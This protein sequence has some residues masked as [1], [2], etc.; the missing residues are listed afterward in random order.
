MNFGIKKYNIRLKG[1]KKQ[2]KV[3]K[4]KTQIIF[5]TNT[6]FDC[7]TC[8]ITEIIVIKIL[9]TVFNCKFNKY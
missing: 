6:S 3:K 7:T 5:T 4:I 1:V 2:K 8:T 9:S